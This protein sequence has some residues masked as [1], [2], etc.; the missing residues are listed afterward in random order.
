MNWSI[1]RKAKSI[2]VHHRLTAGGGMRDPLSVLRRKCSAMERRRSARASDTGGMLAEVRP[3]KNWTKRASIAEVPGSRRRTTVH[4]KFKRDPICAVL[5]LRAQCEWI[6]HTAHENGTR[7]HV[8]ACWCA[9]V[10]PHSFLHTRGAMREM[11]DPPVRINF[12]DGAKRLAS[13][14]HLTMLIFDLRAVWKLR[15]QIHNRV[16]CFR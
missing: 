13:A 6:A 3:L 15:K 12:F 10:C 9:C 2:T 8:Y 16:F 11:K 7:L 4:T 14:L 5:L 1:R